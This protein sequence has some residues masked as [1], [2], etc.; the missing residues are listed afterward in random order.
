LQGIEDFNLEHYTPLYAHLLLELVRD[1]DQ[2]SNVRGEP[3]LSVMA[4]GWFCEK[5]EKSG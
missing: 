5:C 3:V 2:R 1:G 4:A